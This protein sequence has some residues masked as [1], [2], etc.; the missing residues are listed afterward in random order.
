MSSATTNTDDITTIDIN[1]V[2]D[3]MMEEENDNKRARIDHIRRLKGLVYFIGYSSAL[4]FLWGVVA[5]SIMVVSKGGIMVLPGSILGC[6]AVFCVEWTVRD[7]MLLDVK[8]YKLG[9]R[10]ID[11]DRA[12]QASVR[13]MVTFEK[14][15]IFLGMAPLGVLMLI[16]IVLLACYVN[17]SFL[18][19]AL[20]ICPISMSSARRILSDNKARCD[21]IIRFEDPKKTLSSYDG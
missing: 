12:I 18:I 15:F 19:Y 11:P 5:C 1:T 21:E 7:K 8:A 9:L 14:K 17:S 3:D 4:L 16:G 10:S 6:L 20:S 2:V 13:A